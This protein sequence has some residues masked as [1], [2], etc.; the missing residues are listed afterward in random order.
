MRFGY[1]RVSSQDQNTERQE[2]ALAGH[3]DEIFVEMKSGKDS[4]RS[5][6]ESLLA[7]L[8]AGDELV[9][10]SIDRLARNTKDLLTLMDELVARGV[11]VRFLD[12]AMS[13]DNSPT[14][15]FM[16][17]MMGAVAELERGFINQR[18]RE[19]IAIAKERGVYQGKPKNAELRKTLAKL[20][21]RGM[22]A[23]EAAKVAKCGRATAFRIKKELSEA[24]SGK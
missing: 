15:R 6:L 5:V 24:S 9:V 14:S 19:G 17:T 1:V 7:R 4:N 21:A 3:C 12:N 13:F 18:Q 20:F 16:L 11:T 22:S 8:R 10:K 2:A 23:E